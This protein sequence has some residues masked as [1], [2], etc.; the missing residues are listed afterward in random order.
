MV[1]L[2]FMPFWCLHEP[3]LYVRVPSLAIYRG[4]DS[5]LVIALL[6]AVA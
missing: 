2:V 3:G 6:P 5:V 1:T 4:C